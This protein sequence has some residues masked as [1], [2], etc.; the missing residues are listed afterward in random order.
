M[1]KERGVEEIAVECYAGYKGEEAPRSFIHQNRPSR[2]WK[3]WIAGM[4]E[5]SILP[6]FS[7][8]TSR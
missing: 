7:T 8:T 4:K 1:K 2:F 5:E 6:G 3:F